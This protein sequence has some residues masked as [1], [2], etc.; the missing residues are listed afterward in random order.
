METLYHI[1]PL[2]LDAFNPPA[3]IDPFTDGEEANTKADE[4]AAST[5]V[6][7][8]VIKIVTSS[9]YKTAEG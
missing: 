8:E 9:V 3:L 6:Q 7:Y 5:G 4:L 2:M 1:R